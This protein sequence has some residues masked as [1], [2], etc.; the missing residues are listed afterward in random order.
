MIM[1]IF[2]VS[3]LYA[4]FSLLTTPVVF[5]QTPSIILNAP[6]PDQTATVGIPFNF[7]I[8]S[9]YTFFLPSITSSVNGTTTYGTPGFSFSDGTFP[10]FCDQQLYLSSGQFTGTPAKGDI[11]TFHVPVSIGVS[12]IQTGSSVN[13][14]ITTLKIIVQDNNSQQILLIEIIVPAVGALLLLI[15]AF[16]IIYKRLNK[17]LKRVDRII[18]GV[19][20]TDKEKEELFGGDL[21][22][23]ISYQ[24][25]HQEVIRKVK[26]AL[27]TDFKV[28]MDN[29]KMVVGDNLY[30]AME[31]GIRAA[32]V[33]VMCISGAYASSVNC[34]READLAAALK[35]PI[36][37]LLMSDDVVWPPIGLGAIVGGLLYKD[38]RSA[39]DP[40]SFDRLLLDLKYTLKDIISKSKSTV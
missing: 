31:K 23:F 4:I 8:I 11:R 10:D 1:K 27:L 38:F 30:E 2:Q 19:S 9:F 6:I 20:Y 25:N 32:K 40:A 13:G 26:N 34:K 16:V 17:R 24:W 5:T 39:S 36:V 7:S 22:V 21:D 18:T 28:W 15:I 37:P 3:L 12:I 29:D 33:I 35:I 14:N